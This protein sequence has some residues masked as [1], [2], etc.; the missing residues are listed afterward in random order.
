M[1]SEKLLEKEVSDFYDSKNNFLIINCEES[2][3]QNMKFLL[4][5]LKNF[6]KNKNKIFDKAVK[7][8]II[9]V[10]HLLRKIEP[11]NKDIFISN[12]LDIPQTFIDDIYG[13]EIL[14]NEALNLNLDGFFNEFFKN[15]D[16][17]FKDNLYSC[18]S[19]IQY[20]IQDNLIEEGKYCLNIIESIFNNEKLINKIIKRI[21]NE[22]AKNQKPLYFCKHIFENNKFQTKKCF[23]NILIDEL[24]NEFIENMK[25]FIINSEKI[26]ILSSLSKSLPQCAK[27]IW[28][29]LLEEFDFSGKVNTHIKSNKIKIWT[30]LNLPSFN[31]INFVK[32]IIENDY[33]RYI[34]E[35]LKEETSIR[36]FNEPSEIILYLYISMEPEEC[37]MKENLVN[38]FFEEDNNDLNDPT[39]ECVREEI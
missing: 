25:K 10:I 2:D 35:Y 4:E 7:K 22:M 18:F 36:F 29:N 13:N 31:S 34:D 5:Y 15:L 39:F 11:Y 24:E 16:E 23:I 21:I 28:L 33:N 38:E 17:I 3:S 8:I 6:E 27:K 30:K 14:I 12:S 9:L 37:E 19:T 32:S 1:K 20:K 26:S